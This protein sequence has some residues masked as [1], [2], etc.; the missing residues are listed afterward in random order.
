MKA[1]KVRLWAMIGT[2]RNNMMDKWELWEKH[3]EKMTNYTSLNEGTN[4]KS[5]WELWE[6]YKEHLV[7]HM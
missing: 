1:F 2:T 6:Q 5:T 7:K 4:V 3:K